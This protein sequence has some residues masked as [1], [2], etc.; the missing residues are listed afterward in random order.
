VKNVLRTAEGLLSQV[1]SDKVKLLV[2]ALIT[3]Y[4][5]QLTLDGFNS[6]R[7]TMLLVVLK[8]PALIACLANGGQS[9]DF[10]SRPETRRF[11][12]SPEDS[13]PKPKRWQAW[14]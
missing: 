5:Q 6:W 7:S 12:L 3:F 13:G 1:V 2:T 8:A 4:F 9:G 14:R 10:L 11:S